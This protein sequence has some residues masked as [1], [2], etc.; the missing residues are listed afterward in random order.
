MRALL[1]PYNLLRI[2]AVGALLA[3]VLMVAAFML[4]GPVP[5]IVFMSAGQGLGTLS[6]ALYVVVIIL[7]LR[8]AGVLGPPSE[9]DEADADVAGDSEAGA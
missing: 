1:H 9:D 2:A 7:D 3:L 5:L 6:F 8:R 4:P